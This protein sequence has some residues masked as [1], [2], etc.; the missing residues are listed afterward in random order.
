M[1]NVKV[2]DTGPVSFELRAGEMVALAGL[3]GAGQE[4][5]G[6]LLF[7]CRPQE[8]GQITLS[9]V[10]FTAT[11]PGEAMSAG[12]SFVAGDRLHESL[13][14]GMMVRE[15]LFMNPCKHGHALFSRYNE[16]SEAPLSREKIRQFDVRPA[17]INIE[18]SALSGG[19]QQK[20]VMARWLS[21]NAPLLILEDPSAGVDV[22]ARAE[23]YDLLNQ[24]LQNGVAILVISN[25]L[26]EVAH[27]CN[28]ALVFNRGQIVGELLNQDVTFA[29]LL[30]LASGSG[31]IH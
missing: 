21:L 22:G 31:T 12:I 27:I 29:R 9:G 23:I 10:P 15:N 7:A 16:K 13:I 5:I 14:P 25:D 19:N 18:I 1:D 2:G 17:Q 4:E 8:S 30:E 6:R 24:A 28:R 20:V 26:E 11:T 3:R